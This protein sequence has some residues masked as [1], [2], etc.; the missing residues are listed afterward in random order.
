MG[1]GQLSLYNV[2]SAYSVLD[3]EVCDFR[4]TLYR[5]KRSFI[6]FCGAHI[7]FVF[8]AVGGLLPGPVLRYWSAAVTLGGGRRLQHAQISHVCLG[9]PPTIQA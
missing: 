4:Q 7:G 3:P 8:V 9:G 2:L 5:P 1:P 6:S